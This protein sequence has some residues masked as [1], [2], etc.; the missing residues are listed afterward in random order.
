MV[1]QL[2]IIRGT[3]LSLDGTIVNITSDYIG[4]D[5]YVAVL[6]WKGVKIEPIMIKTKYLQEIDHKDEYTYKVYITKSNSVGEIIDSEMVTISDTIKDIR[7]QSISEFIESNL[8]PLI[9]GN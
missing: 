4:E 2:Y 8:R 7:I 9:K 1:K 5:G 3:G 6:P